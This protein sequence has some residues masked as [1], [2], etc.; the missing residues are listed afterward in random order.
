MSHQQDEQ[1]PKSLGSEDSEEPQ[2]EPIRDSVSRPVLV[3]LAAL[4]SVAVA[5]GLI[6]AGG[7]LMVTKVLGLGGDDG[8]TASSGSSRSLYLPEISDTEA[9]EGQ[10]G[11]TDSPPSPDAFS[12]S[13]DAEPAQGIKLTADP[14]EAAVN[15]QITLMVDYPTGQDA[16][17]QVQRKGAAGW[18]DFP[19]SP[20][21]MSGRPHASTWIVSSLTGSFQYRVR[22][23]DSGKTSKPV[24]IT[25]R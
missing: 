16:I 9:G 4:L 24:T 14:L 7:V 5:V 13:A 20:L 25:L 12:E 2:G 8:S 6:V 21:N 11:A 17:L 22:D 1:P 23:T 18:E 3:G 10:G 15:T 19:A